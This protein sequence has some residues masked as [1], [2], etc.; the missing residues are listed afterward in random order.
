MI[1]VK[2]ILRM[3]SI[4]LIV[5]LS[6][7]Y[8]KYQNLQSNF[9]G[10]Q[11]VLDAREAEIKSYVGENG[12]LRQEKQTAVLNES[13]SKK[14][15]KYYEQEVKDLKENHGV[16]VKNLHSYYRAKLKTT[17]SGVV[18]VTDT[19][20]IVNDSIK[21]IYPRVNINDQYLTLSGYFTNDRFKYEYS[22]VDSMSVAYSW[23]QKGIWPFR[24]NDKLNI[25]FSS[26]NPNTRLMNV[27][28]FVITPENSVKGLYTG[29]G[30]NTNTGLS[31][32][33]M[34]LKDRMSYEYEYH[35]EK[36]HSVGVKFRIL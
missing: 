27:T 36:S 8:F 31:L 33:A 5:L 3:G 13:N 29:L 10:I 15:L 34:Y 2:T 25:S 6:I 24:T 16:K 17:G 26:A 1:T 9:E 30:Y 18:V 20:I 35:L 23:T 11:E 12:R 22:V 21:E 4:A 32:E 19:T 14:A 28:S 7:Y